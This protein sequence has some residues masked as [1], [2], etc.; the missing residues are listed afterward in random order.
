MVSLEKVDSC[1]PINAM[2]S[3]VYPGMP[4]I[5]QKKLTAV[6]PGML[7]I[8]Q[9]KLIAV[10]P[11][12]PLILQRNLTALYTMI[13]WMMMMMNFIFLIPMILIISESTMCKDLQICWNYWVRYITKQENGPAFVQLYESDWN[14]RISLS[15]KKY[16][17]PKMLPLSED[18]NKLNSYLK[19]KI[20][21]PLMKFSNGSAFYL[22]L[23]KMTLCHMT[24][25]NRKRG[26]DV[27]RITV[28][29][30]KQA[31]E[32]Q[33]SVPYDDVLKSSFVV[34]WLELNSMANINSEKK[35]CK[36]MLQIF[37]C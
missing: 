8:L 7:Q 27:Q 37:I 17:T 19:E 1:V 34:L 10:Y 14:D 23:A 31:I 26:G 15:E 30:Y 11:G 4:Q 24:L 5:L 33:N 32:A 22:E 28:D 13:S 18:V 2:Y 21:E 12:M 9:K 3:P 6:N 20:R 25:F 29:H 36:C 35:W 16:N